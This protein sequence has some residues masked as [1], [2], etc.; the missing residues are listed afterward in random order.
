MSSYLE[1]QKL[2]KKNQEL[3]SW[4]WFYSNSSEYLQVSRYPKAS[5]L[6]TDRITGEIKR[7]TII[8]YLDFSK[9]FK[10]DKE[11]AFKTSLEI[12]ANQAKINELYKNKNYGKAN[13]RTN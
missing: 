2:I 10:E 4:N 12:R 1:R 3:Y 7:V 9:R 6:V 8:P 11:K 13:K 5:K